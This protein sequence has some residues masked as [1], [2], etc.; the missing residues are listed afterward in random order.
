MYLISSGEVGAGF[1]LFD[2]PID[3]QQY[4]LTHTLVNKDLFGDYY[5]LFNVKAE[6]MFI[7]VQDVE[8]Y[9]INKKYLL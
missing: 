6:F 1:K 5:V 7:A 3:T 8:A 2:Q 4:E 9:A